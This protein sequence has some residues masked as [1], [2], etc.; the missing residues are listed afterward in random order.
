MALAQF[1][2]PT[3]E[4][5]K[6]TS[7]PKA[8]GAD[9]VYLYVEEID[10]DPMRTEM[11][12]FRIK[13]LSEKAKELA[14]VELPYLKEGDGKIASIQG[15]T[16]H[17]DGTVI[18]LNVK[19][20]DLLVEKSGEMQ[21]KQKTFSL[22]SVEVGSILEYRFALRYDEHWIIP[23]IWEV[24]KK[25][26]VRKAHY[27]FTPIQ[28]GLLWWTR[29]PNGATVKK[30][31]AGRYS[32]DVA[33]VSPI[34]YEEWMPPIQSVL[35]KVLFYYDESYTAEAF[36]LTAGKQWQREVNHF[37][38]P[39]KTIRDA[40]AGIVAPGDS[41]LDKAQKLYK[42]VQALDNTDYSRKIG[43]SERKELNLKVQK[44]AQDTWNQKSGSSEDIALLY[45]AMLR[46]AAL[47]AY[48]TKV[49]DR[50]ER[51]FDPTFLSTSQLDDTLVVANLGGKEMFLDPG[52]KMCPFGT[53]SWKHSDTAGL[54]E[55]ADGVGIGSTPEQRYT[56]NT[57]VRSGD[58][59]LDPHGGITG[60]V[61]FLYN[62]QEALRWR[63]LALENDD[64]EVKKRFDH[65]LESIVPA[66]V[67]AHVDHFLGMDAPDANL[68]AIVKV[69]GS[70][71][72]ATSKRLLVPGFFFE[73]RGAAPFVNEEKRLEPVDMHYGDQVTEDITYNLPPGMSVEAAPQETKVSWA[74]HAAYV[75]NSKTDPG[76]VSIHRTMARAFTFAKAQEYQDLRGFYAK[77]AAADQQQLVL[78]TAPAAR[79]G[80]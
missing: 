1:Q 44:R 76:Q 46:A 20:E 56:A 54:R 10:D 50:G 12:Y 53:L 15:R 55:L 72:T 5:L 74:G 33:N 16:I 4:E 68:M 30:D 29:L 36:W 73:S 26:F 48:A 28:T 7:D 8:P 71:G 2:T 79:K 58:L 32:V 17:A 19:P 35:Y 25:Y 11:F 63:Q 24:Q 18:P 61:T 49:T 23:P 37:A 40:V 47:P 51:M 42:A 43:E 22:P 70:L 77:V 64:A 27:S 75:A 13:I 52:E 78:A 57:L 65:E 31:V 59:T 38:D 45:M 21:V 39:N 67:E 34:P 6:M 9:A 41:D 62:G 60:S 69:T 80:N 3:E 66:G 14:T